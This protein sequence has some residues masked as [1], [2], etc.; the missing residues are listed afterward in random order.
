MKFKVTIKPSENF[1][2]ES[3]TINAISIYEAVIF[4]D[5]MLRAAGASPCDIL[6]VE[7]IIEKESI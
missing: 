3:M 1:K 7:N 6:M 5:D 4:A 2:A